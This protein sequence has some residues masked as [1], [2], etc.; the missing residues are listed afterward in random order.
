MTL[1][2]TGHRWDVFLVRR[3]GLDFT[4]CAD[5]RH[6]VLGPVWTIRWSK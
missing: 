1:L 2:H 4:R 3:W 6:F 5:H